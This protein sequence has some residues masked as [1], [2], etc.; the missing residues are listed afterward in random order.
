MATL[1]PQDETIVELWD[2]G[3]TIEQIV[4][5]TGL[6]NR[7]V[8]SIISTSKVSDGEYK[9]RKAAMARGSAMLLAAIM[10]ARGARGLVDEN[11]NSVSEFV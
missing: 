4:A 6:T 1:N 5:Q 11:T 7:R 9:R 10:E 2:G 8:Y 3:M